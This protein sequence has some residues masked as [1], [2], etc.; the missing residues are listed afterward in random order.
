MWVFQRTSCESSKQMVMFAVS[1]LVFREICKSRK[2]QIP[3]QPWRRVNNE[4]L[5]ARNL[6]QPGQ[7]L[8]MFPPAFLISSILSV[9][10]SCQFLLPNCTLPSPQPICFV[11]PLN[12][13][14]AKNWERTCWQK[15]FTILQAVSTYRKCKNTSLSVLN[16][17][18]AI[19]TPPLEGVCVPMPMVFLKPWSEKRIF[20]RGQEIIYV[21]ANQTFRRLRNCRLTSDE[22]MLASSDTQGRVQCSHHPDVISDC[23]F[24]CTSK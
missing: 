5:Q 15:V 7:V 16:S 3:G 13:P 10:H 21:G 11:M 9:L 8:Q 20:P 23:Y 1:L 24:C 22:R 12:N 18:N 17:L 2:N 6:K 4:L 14:E 19:S